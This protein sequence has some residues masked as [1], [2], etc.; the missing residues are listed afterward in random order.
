[1][2]GYSKVVQKTGFEE[3]NDDV[4]EADFWTTSIRFIP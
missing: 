3:I 1:M 2:V 4:L